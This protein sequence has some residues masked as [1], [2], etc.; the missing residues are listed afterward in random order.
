MGLMALLRRAP[1]EVYRVFS[2][3]DFLA[4][5]DADE[6]WQPVATDAGARRRPR[7]IA[8]TAML[9]GAVAAV[10]AVLVL[11]R[12]PSQAPGRSIAPP[13]PGEARPAFPRSASGVARV[14]EDPR[15]MRLA[16]GA[17]RARTLAATSSAGRSSAAGMPAPPVSAV[18]VAGSSAQLERAE[19]GFER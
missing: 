12:P 15:A 19:F 18:A 2:E 8:V 9:A 4:G 10:G 1:R 7:R 3:S 16:V 6:Q 11:H 5:G 13:V 17:A 14:S